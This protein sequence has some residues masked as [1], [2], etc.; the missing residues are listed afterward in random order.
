MTLWKLSK[1]LISE[2]QVLFSFYFDVLTASKEIRGNLQT[3]VIRNPTPL[4]E[5]HGFIQLSCS[6]LCG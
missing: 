4:H 5:R 1:I 3:G 6:S 2:V